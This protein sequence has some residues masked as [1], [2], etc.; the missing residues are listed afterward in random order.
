MCRA[1]QRHH[2]RRISTQPIPGLSNY[3]S[4]I[5]AYYERYGFSIR[6]SQRSRSAFRCESRAFGADLGTLDCN[7]ETVQDAQLNYTF[8]SGTFENL[9]LYLQ[10]SNLGDEPS[11]AVYRNVNGEDLPRIVLRIR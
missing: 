10:F 5:T 6:Y 7:G 4:N 11:T 2:K 3:V 1:L 9:S 8:G